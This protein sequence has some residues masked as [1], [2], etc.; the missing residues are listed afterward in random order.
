MDAL[1]TE[2]GVPMLQKHGDSTAI[3]ASILTKYNTTMPQLYL[4]L[5]PYTANKDKMA[6]LYEKVVRNLE[7]NDKH[8]AE[9][10]GGIQNDKELTN[11][12]DS[13]STPK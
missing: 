13:A 10:L 6:A 4:S 8:Y 3:Y 1:C 9:E 11:A 2:N 5:L 7:M 12:V